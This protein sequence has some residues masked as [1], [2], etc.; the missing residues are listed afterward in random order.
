MIIKTKLNTLVLFGFGGL[1]LFLS[2]MSF[3]KHKL[4]SN[5]LSN[6]IHKNKDTRIKKSIPNCKTEKY[7]FP[8]DVNN[9]V[10]AIIDDRTCAY[11][12]IQTMNKT[13]YTWGNYRLRAG[14]SSDVH[15]PRMERASRVVKKINSGNYVRI[16][17]VCRIKRVG[18]LKNRNLPNTVAD[19]DGTYFIQAKGTHYAEP[20]KELK[21][22]SD[23]AI[24]LFLA[25]PHYESDGVTYNSFDI[26]REEIKYRGGEGDKGRNVIYITNVEKNKDFNVSVVTGFSRTDSNSPIVHYVNAEINGVT[27]N[28]IVPS[29]ERAKEAKLRMGA[30]RC[31]GGEAE[32]LWRSGV[33]SA[34]INK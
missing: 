34:I 7:T 27:A 2:L 18:I 29:P 23:P 12:Y 16:D 5:D 3:D 20:G 13:E 32:I 22:S 11:D 30:Y 10:D 9:G 19:K 24:C 14:T 4:H 15:H 6:K 25:K 33:T 26:Y 17:G 31:L 21:G 8:D 1:L 28:F